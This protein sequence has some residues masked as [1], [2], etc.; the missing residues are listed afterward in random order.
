MYAKCFGVQNENMYFWRTLEV[1]KRKSDFMNDFL[2]QNLKVKEVY[3]HVYIQCRISRR[4]D[5][6][7]R[8]VGVGDIC[9]GVRVRERI[10]MG[11]VAVM[12]VIH[13]H[14]RY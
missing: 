9:F 14:C 6:W 2:L 5:G 10:L 3:H 13:S 1:M 4:M 8:R 12:S 7:E 11:R